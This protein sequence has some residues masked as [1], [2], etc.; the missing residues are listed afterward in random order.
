MSG[1]EIRQATIEDS[2]LIHKFVI[3]LATYEK[4]EHE[5]LATVADI[6][7]ALFGDNTTTKAVICYFNN[8]PIG[9]AVYFFNFSTWLGKHGLYLEDLYVTQKYRGVGAGKALLKYLANIAISKKCGR[10][11]WNVLDWNEPAIQF[12]E[13]IGAKPQ[14][15]W[16]GYR[17]TGK[18]L[19]DF[20]VS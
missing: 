9:F 17:L 19:E 8:E 12:Y 7:N 14:N 15:E 5:V 16:I 10:F 4:A 3:E 6:E 11:E 20:A 2:A 18:A 13:S 1:V